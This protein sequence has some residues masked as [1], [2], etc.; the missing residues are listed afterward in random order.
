MVRAISK[1]FLKD[2]KSGA[3]NPLLEMVHVDDTL[4]LELRGESVNIYYRGGSLFKITAKG[5][6]SYDIFFDIRYCSTA[7]WSATGRIVVSNPSI[8]QAVQ[9]IPFYK[10]AMDMW[11]SKHP[12]YEKEAQQRIVLENNNQ[13]SIS[14]GTDCFIIDTE[15]AFA[16]YRFDMIGLK[17]LSDGTIRKGSRDTSLAIIELKYGDGALGGTAGIRK[18]LTDID[19]FIRSGAV[20]AFKTD[21]EDVFEQKRQLGLVN[22]LLHNKNHVVVQ[23]K[24]PDAMFIFANHDPASTTLF[25]ILRTINP[26]AYGFTIWIA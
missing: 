15:Y 22:A 1:D 17:W 18:H 10:Q 6:H 14:N 11:F 26:A 20:P 24:L 12:R 23:E 2:L 9:N 16:N 5:A 8:T 7:A 19:S 25:S 4:D 13:G 21:M 3:L